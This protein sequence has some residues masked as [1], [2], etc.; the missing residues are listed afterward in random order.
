MTAEQA[1]LNIDKQAFMYGK[2]VNKSARWNLCFDERGSEP[3]YEAAKGRIISYEEVPVTKTLKDQ[4]EHY[5]GEKAKNLK[6][7]GNYYY[8]IDKCGI[9]FHGDAERRK[10]LAVRLGDA[11]MPIYFQWH[12]MNLKYGDIMEF[13]LNS[14]DMY[15]MS[16]KAVGTDW[17]RKKVYTLRHAAGCSRFTGIKNV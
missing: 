16:E 11:S 14:G 2:V 17:R 3:N 4:F 13:K 6:G 12:R 1:A 15:V 8:D 10:V 5:F 9:G 7:E